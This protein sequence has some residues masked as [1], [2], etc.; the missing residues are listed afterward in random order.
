MA[1]MANRGNRLT[2]TLLQ[3]LFR[4][5]FCMLLVW[6]AGYLVAHLFH[7]TEKLNPL[8]NKVED[9]ELS[10]LCFAFGHRQVDEDTAIIIF[11]EDS[12]ANDKMSE[13]LS[14]IERF[15]ARSVAIDLVFNS[16]DSV[17][18]NRLID[19][20]NKYKKNIVLAASVEP[21]QKIDTRYHDF[22]NA[23]AGR[24]DGNGSYNWGYLKSEGEMQTHRY[25][26]PYLQ[27]G[28]GKMP[29]F[30]LSVLEL[31]DTKYLDSIQKR[32]NEKELINY[33]RGFHGHP[34]YH[35][36]DSFPPDSAS[37]TGK[38]VLIGSMDTNSVADRYYS[39]LNKYIGRSYP[40]MDGVEYHAQILSM[41]IANDFIDEESTPIK[42]L[43]LF[44][45][46]YIC[47]FLFSWA[48]KFHN[49]YHLLTEVFLIA[50]L[51][52]LSLTICL[53]LLN[54][55]H[56]ML[57]PVTYIVP[58]FFSGVALHFYEPF[59]K[60]LSAISQKINFKKIVYATK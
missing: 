3:N 43:L 55:F 49:L 54:D 36:F 48:M 22:Y 45:C 60:L 25:F 15:Q 53:L 32:G 40:D 37:V 58:I 41:I 39:P 21:S 38:I 42:Y 20:I 28:S 4:T 11:R 8:T 30:E 51:V 44:I 34:R 27:I 1:N 56:L 12:V 31:T 26:E 33:H 7:F 52:P 47:M 6:I 59:V 10:D 5:L 13:E 46:N 57:E 29:S 24:N 14:Q 18:D 50:I 23:M 17:R 16:Y 35:V 9:F 2:H 19:T